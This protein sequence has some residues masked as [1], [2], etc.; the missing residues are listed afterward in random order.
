MLEWKEHFSTQDDQVDDQHKKLFKLVNDFEQQVRDD[1][2]RS[3]YREV[4]EFLGDYAK[5]HFADE[6]RIMEEKKCSIAQE[7][8]EAH[9]QFLNAYSGFVNRFQTEGYSEPLANE[10]LKTTQDWLVK[11]ICGVDVRLRHCGVMV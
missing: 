9:D 6:E 7:N 8:K 5:V 2:A 4:L 11:H 3:G 10:L 1:Q